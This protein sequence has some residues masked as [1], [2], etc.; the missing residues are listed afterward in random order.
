MLSDF[1]VAR[2][3]HSDIV[4]FDLLRAFDVDCQ[5]ESANLSFLNFR[6]GFL[7]LIHNN[8]STDMRERATGGAC[9]RQW[10]DPARDKDASYV[11]DS[12]PPQGRESRA[13]SFLVHNYCLYLRYW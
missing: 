3:K 1:R 5:Q 4:E 6:V 2:S 12:P 11:Q 7:P 9:Q 8:K 10:P 13:V